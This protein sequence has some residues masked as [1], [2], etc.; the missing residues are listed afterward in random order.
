MASDIIYDTLQKEKWSRQK[1]D[2]KLTAVGFAGLVTD[3]KT[4]RE[5]RGS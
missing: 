4:Y 3:Y 5:F 1:T 2:N